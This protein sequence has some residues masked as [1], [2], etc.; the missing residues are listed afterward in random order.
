MHPAGHLIVALGAP[1]RAPVEPLAPVHGIH[2]LAH[3][4]LLGRDAQPEPTV[5]TFAGFQKPVAHQVLQN[6]GEKMQRNAGFRRNVLYQ[7]ELILRQRGQVDKRTNRVLSRTR[8]DHHNTDLSMLAMVGRPIS[9]M[10][11]SNSLRRISITRVTP[12]GP[13]TPRPHRYGR[14]I[15]TA[16]APRPSALITS[17][18]RR[19]PPSTRIGTRPS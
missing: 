17:V 8:I 13:A 3:R 15:C 2:Q 7:R 11:I 12:S 6:L 18:P 19:I 10:V 1:R 16:V 9:I 4:N 14:P 5:R